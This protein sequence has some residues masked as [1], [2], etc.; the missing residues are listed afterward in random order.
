MLEASACPCTDK[1][2]VSTN[3]RS[4]CLFG[5]CDFHFWEII[6]LKFI[7]SILSRI[8]LGAIY[9]QNTWNIA[10]FQWQFTHSVTEASHIRTRT[11]KLNTKMAIW[12]TMITRYQRN[13]WFVVNHLGDFW[14]RGGTLFWASENYMN[15]HWPSSFWESLAQMASVVKFSF[16]HWNRQIFNIINNKS[17]LQHSMVQTSFIPFVGSW[18]WDKVE[19]ILLSKLCSCENKEK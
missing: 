9:G 10:F 19:H 7:F 17:I 5:E 3:Y 15:V 14:G 18:K 1:S 8:P 11:S 16:R 12:V 13:I 2:Q 4:L 6:L